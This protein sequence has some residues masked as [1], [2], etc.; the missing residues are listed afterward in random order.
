MS[1]NTSLDFSSFIKALDEL[2]D[3][4][5]Y[6]N[7]DLAQQDPGLR[8][9]LMAGTIQAFEFTYEI[10]IKFI[11]RYLEVTEA[12]REF[13]AGM[14]FPEL[15]RTAN[16]RNLLKNDVVMWKQYRDKRNITSHTYD[17]HQDTQ[18]MDVIPL[19]VQDAIF[20]LNKLQQ[21]M[22]S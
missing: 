17:E 21:R 7:S 3:A 11:R 4:I 10:S 8:R 9:H 19:F 22:M 14:T 12:S 18:V 1:I 16:E 20:L 5:K 2:I 13:I 15:I 6:Y